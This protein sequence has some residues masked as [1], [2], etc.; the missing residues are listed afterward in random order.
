[1]CN[2]VGYTVCGIGASKATSKP[3]MSWAGPISWWVATV[4][5]AAIDFSCI[6]PSDFAGGTR[7]IGYVSLTVHCNLL[8]RQCHQLDGKKS[9]ARLP[10]LLDQ[11]IALGARMASPS[12]L[13]H[14]LLARVRQP[15]PA[16]RV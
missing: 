9:A 3:R 4:Q 10:A 1:V 8:C 2:E 14:G 13:A 16:L 5:S 11:D 12:T 15:A 6:A 7:P